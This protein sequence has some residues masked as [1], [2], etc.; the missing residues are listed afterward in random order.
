MT[1]KDLSAMLSRDVESVLHDLLPNGKREGNH[2]VVGSLGGEEGKSMKVTLQGN[3]AGKWTDFATGEHGDLI[4]LWVEARG[5]TIAKAME[6][7]ARYLGVSLDRPGFVTA[8]ARAW[9][10][11]NPI[12]TVVREESPVIAY[13]KGRGI[14][15][16]TQRRFRISEKGENIIFPFY[17]SEGDL[18]LAKWRSVVDKKKTGVTKDCRPILFGWQAVSPKTRSIVICEGEIDA[19]SFLEYGVEALSVPFGGGTGAKQAWIEHEFDNLQRFDEV[20][21]AL[22]MDEVG[23]KAAAEIVERIGRHRCRVAE[24]PCKDI[25]ECLTTGVERSVIREA[26]QNARSQDPA[27]LR[28]AKEFMDDILREFNPSAEEAGFDLLW[29][30]D[31]TIQFRPGEV[32]LLAGVNGHGKSEGMGHILLEAI[33]QGEKGCVASLEFKPQRWLKRLVLQ[34][35]GLGNPTDNYIRKIVSWMSP[36]VWVFDVATVAKTDTLLEV[37]SYARRKYGISVFVIDNLSKLDIDL[38]DYN[39]QREFMDRLTDFAKQHNV[40]VFLVTHVRK[41]EDDSKPTGK[42][43]IKGSGALTDLADTVIIWWRNRKKE[44]LL[45]KPNLTEIEIEDLER[46]PDAMMICEKQRNGDDEPRINLWWHAPS[47]QFLSAP[48]LRP[49]EYVRFTDGE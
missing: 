26:I 35:S 48:K 30:R 42:M 22:D 2:W 36:S 25:N 40:H 23:Q 8:G 12:V 14:S 43:D 10:K 38:D 41:G 13:L 37:F 47:H 7:I 15:L 9:S 16:E 46:K 20:I 1:P 17:S 49:R 39:G 24:L 18:T 28:N 32:T 45:K 44:Q 19:M 11:P 5:V 33:S 4:D 31:K 34:A 27:E 3:F 21:L 6:E 29:Q